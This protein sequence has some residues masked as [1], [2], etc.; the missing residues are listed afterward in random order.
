MGI[1]I[2]GKGTELQR[3]DDPTGGVTVEERS[4]KTNISK[5]VWVFIQKHVGKNTAI[6][7]PW[8]WA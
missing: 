2:Y 1:Y 3:F 7:S 4:G 6:S 5:L 8:K